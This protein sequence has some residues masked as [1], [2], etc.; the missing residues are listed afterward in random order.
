MLTLPGV[1]ET[2]F[3]GTVIVLLVSLHGLANV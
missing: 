1:Q 3:V 2:E